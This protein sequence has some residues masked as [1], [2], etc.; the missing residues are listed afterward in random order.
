MFYEMLS[1][2]A[3]YWLSPHVY[4][5]PLLIITA[6]WLPPQETYAIEQSSLCN[7]S[8][9]RGADDL[10]SEGSPTPNCPSV[11]LPKEKRNPSPEMKAA[12]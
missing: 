11:F 2:V 9:K 8:T 5:S 3:P 7:E 10:T 1:P 6:V 12:W 4:S